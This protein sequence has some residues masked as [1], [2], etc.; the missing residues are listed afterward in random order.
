MLNEV[1]KPSRAMSIWRSV[2]GKRVIWISVAVIFAATPACL[3]TV[4]YL[5]VDWFADPGCWDGFFDPRCYSADGLRAG[6]IYALVYACVAL[7][8]A[9][10]FIC[11][12]AFAVLW[13]IGREAGRA[14]FFGMGIGSVAATVTLLVSSI[15]VYFFTDLERISLERGLIY[16]VYA[17][18]SASSVRAA[19]DAG[20]DVNTR[21][22]ILGRTPLH[23]NTGDPEAVQMLVDAG[24]DVNARDNYGRTPLHRSVAVAGSERP[25]VVRVLVDAGADVNAKDND[26]KTPLHSMASSDSLKVIQVLVAAGADVNE[27]DNEGR[28][29]LHDVAAW[30]NHPNVP[31]ALM[32]ELMDAGADVNAKDHDGKTP[33]DLAREHANSDTIRLLQE[34]ADP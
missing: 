23:E 21:E 15:V 22:G 26:G 18:D 34:A 25:E 7:A 13:R 6:F 33:L 4:L 14:A 11:S 32:R 24:A 12:M 27:K 16:D 1:E 9:Y 2:T 20:V 5:G 30:W 29:L 8:F 10:W 31:P 17:H 19:I 28:T 3:A